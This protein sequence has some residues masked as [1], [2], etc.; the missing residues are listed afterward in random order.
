MSSN[1]NHCAQVSKVKKRKGVSPLTPENSV[2]AGL[3]TPPW[4]KPPPAPPSVPSTPTSPARFLPLLLTSIVLNTTQHLTHFNP[5]FT[6]SLDTSRLLYH[7]CPR[8]IEEKGGRYYWR[9]RPSIVQI[10][11]NYYY[12]L[13]H[14]ATNTSSVPK[15]ITL[16]SRPSMSRP[17]LPSLP[18]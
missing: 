8:R 15:K 7:G 4:P 13:F 9:R 6:Q 10:V 3:N 18:P 12:V 16:P 14:A 11:H 1:S 2:R 17:H 5:H